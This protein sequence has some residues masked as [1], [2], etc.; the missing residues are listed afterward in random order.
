LNIAGKTAL[1]TGGALRIGKVICEALADGGCNVAVHYRTSGAAAAC[2]VDSLRAKGVRASSFQTDMD[3]IREVELLPERVQ[4]AMGEIDFLINNASV[5]HKSSLLESTPES[6]AAEVQVNALAPIALMRALARLRQQEILGWP[7][8]RIVNILD[9]RVAGLE[10]GMLPYQLSKNM[11]RDAT[12]I[13]ALELGPG[14]SVNAVAPGPILPPPGEGVAYLVDKAG[15][16][17]LA[18]RPNPAHVADAVLFLLKSE[19]ITGQVLYVDSGQH[20]L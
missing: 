10:R 15:P 6:I 9:R 5:F 14:F 2:L 17:V 3:D 19:G 8:K 16:M 13:A 12:R 4:A 18:N 11:L 20:L 1:V 7:R